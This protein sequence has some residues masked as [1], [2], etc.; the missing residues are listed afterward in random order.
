[1]LRLIQVRHSG[2]DGTLYLE[3][4][5]G[6]KTKAGGN[7]R[8][9]VEAEKRIAGAKGATVSE[10]AP[11]SPI[12][13]GGGLQ[14]YED[15]GGHLIERHVDLTDADLAQ[16]LATSNISSASRFADRSTAEAAVSAAVDANQATIQNYLASN[17]KGYLAY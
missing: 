4:T 3:T 9:L 17:T 6:L 14:T 2:S 15:A 8:E 16:R 5:A 13:E 11:Y 12:V 10:A 1:V 7:L